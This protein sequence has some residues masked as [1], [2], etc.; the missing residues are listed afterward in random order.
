MN[1]H[2]RL[3]IYTYVFVIR[4]DEEETDETAESEIAVIITVELH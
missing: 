3:L 1:S 4:T 2:I